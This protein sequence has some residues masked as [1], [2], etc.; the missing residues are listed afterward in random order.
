MS[1]Q[2]EVAQLEREFNSTA[3]NGDHCG[4]MNARIRH[5]ETKAAFYRNCYSELGWNQLQ[6]E[7]AASSLEQKAENLRNVGC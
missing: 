7:E 4:A 3:L 5:W 1:E 6:A 2:R